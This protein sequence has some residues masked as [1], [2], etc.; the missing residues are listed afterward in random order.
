MP[1]T[2]ACQKSGWTNNDEADEQF[3][4][5]ISLFNNSAAN[6]RTSASRHLLKEKDGVDGEVVRKA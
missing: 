3:V 1:T 6:A 4:N 2:I 5:S